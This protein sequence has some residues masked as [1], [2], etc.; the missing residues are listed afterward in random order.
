ML[1]KTLEFCFITCKN[2]EAESQLILRRWQ[3][4]TFTPR[5]LRLA[6]LWWLNIEFWTAFSKGKVHDEVLAEEHYKCTNNCGFVQVKRQWFPNSNVW[7]SCWGMIKPLVSCSC[8]HLSVGFE[9]KRIWLFFLLLLLWCTGNRSVGK[10]P[11][12]FSVY[13][14]HNSVYHS[15][16]FQ[17]YIASS[18]GKHHSSV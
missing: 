8:M 2:I 18:G 6:C 5:R 3:P 16:Q 10:E 7:S 17:C 14:L 12:C 4:S 15:L 9:G 13:F 11:L 1:D